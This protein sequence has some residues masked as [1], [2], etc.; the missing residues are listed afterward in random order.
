MKPLQEILKEM[1]LLKDEMVRVIG[2]WRTETV[3]EQREEEMHIKIRKGMTVCCFIDLFI[4]VL[5]Q[6]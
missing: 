5:L 2:S 4:F 6:R 3:S 1:E